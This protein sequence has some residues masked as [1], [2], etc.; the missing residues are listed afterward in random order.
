MTSIKQ[1]ISKI[2]KNYYLNNTF[3]PISYYHICICVIVFV[4]ETNIVFGTYLFYW[5]SNCGLIMMSN[6][7]L[8]K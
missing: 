8:V 1:I 6:L 4:S 7:I 2:F 3:Y 5:G